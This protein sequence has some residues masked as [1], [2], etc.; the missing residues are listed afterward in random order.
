MKNDFQRP[1]TPAE[2]EEMKKLA[3]Q[4]MEDGAFGL[5]AGLEYVPG[6]WSDTQELVE[7]ARAIAPYQAVYISHERSEGRDPMWKNAS[8]P[9]PSADLLEAVKETIEVG[10]KSGITVARRRGLRR[11]IS[12]SDL[13]LRRPD[14][15]D[16]HVVT[17]RRRR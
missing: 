14:C 17:G 1:A 9:T 16:P 12:I 11:S 2:I 4:G 7:I 15:P 8:D 3:R 5:S 6:R 13:R 10:E